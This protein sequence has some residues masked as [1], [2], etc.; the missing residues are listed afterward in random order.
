MKPTLRMVRAI[1]AEYIR[2][3]VQPL[4][5]TVTVVLGVLLV[6]GGW[7]ASRN[8][9]WWI[10]EAV[11]IM[12]S[13][14]YILVVW[15]AWLLLKRVDAAQTKER[16]Q[17]VR[18]FVDKFER[19]AEHVGTPFPLLVLRVVWDMLRP[20]KRGFITEVAED[21]KTLAPDFL[22]LQQHFRD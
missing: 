1:G 7:L 8:A 16:R 2:R 3:K 13:I 15:A 11:F 22:A 10:F 6:L 9:W 18:A 12:A 17:A 14:V 19:V 5:I 21:S 4:L 20:S